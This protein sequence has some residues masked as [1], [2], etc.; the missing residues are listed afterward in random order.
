MPE[1]GAQ[2]RFVFDYP[3]SAALRWTSNMTVAHSSDH[4]AVNP[5]LK[6]AIDLP[7]I[8]P[9]CI[10]GE[11]NKSLNCSLVDKNFP[12]FGSIDKIV[13]DAILEFQHV[14]QHKTIKMV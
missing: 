7:N 12:L 10:L 6:R 3:R 13:Y 1:N 2:A 9:V 11:G 4:N 5:V 14:K 8:G